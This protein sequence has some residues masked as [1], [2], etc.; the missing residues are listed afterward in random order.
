MATTIKYAHSL[1]IGAGMAGLLA[2]RRLT[3]AG[4]SVIVADKARGVGGRMATRCIADAR[5]DHGAQFFTARDP[6]FA[7]MVTGWLEKGAARIWT[8]A[9]PTESGRRLER[10]S[11]FYRAKGGMTAVPKLL[12][13]HLNVAI[14]TEIASVSWKA[15]L[16]EARTRSGAIIRAECLVMTP[17][18]PQAL[19]L[20]DAGFVWLPYEDRWALESIAYDPCL[21]VMA[22]LDGPSGLLEPGALSLESGPIAWIADNFIKGISPNRYAVTVHADVPFSRRFLDGDLDDG[23]ATLLDAAA[24]WLSSPVRSYQVHRWRFSRPSKIHG[25]PCL[26]LSDGR[27][28]VFAGDAFGGPNVEGAALSGLAAADLLLSRTPSKKSASCGKE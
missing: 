3:E 28:L 25:A 24:A 12:A 15:G 10:L 14:G 20:L 13:R 4:R 17:P 8:S 5:L 21:A 2:A 7:R 16:W 1:V 11:P 26:P 27:P 9:F 19:N 22:I 18:V 6:R 23:A